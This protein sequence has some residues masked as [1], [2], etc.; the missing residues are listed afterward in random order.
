[1]QPSAQ[2]RDAIRRV[3][4]QAAT[5][6]ADTDASIAVQEIQLSL[7]AREVNAFRRPHDNLSGILQRSVAVR[8]IL[9]E[10]LKKAAGGDSINL[11]ATLKFAYSESAML[12]DRVTQARTNK[13]VDG[14][15]QLAACSR[16]LQS[17]IEQAEG[18][19]ARPSS[20]SS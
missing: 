17:L 15:L 1:M 7:S 14:A 18:S 20:A 6:T 11:N 3:S 9:M 16:S 13:D 19:M 4:E 5:L 10:S 8:L 2:V 12:Q